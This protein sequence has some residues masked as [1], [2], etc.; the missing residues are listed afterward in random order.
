MYYARIGSGGRWVGNNVGGY[1][2]IVDME[3]LVNV[4]I[5]DDDGQEMQTNR[6]TPAGRSG[7]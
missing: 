3:D 2:H 6:R 5:S 1:Q 7:H 4:P